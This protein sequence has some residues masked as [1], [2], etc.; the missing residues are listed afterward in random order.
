[1]FR[2]APL[3]VSRLRPECISFAYRLVEL[4]LRH[5]N[6][7]FGRA[8][9]LKI[10]HPFLRCA[11]TK[12]ETGRARRMALFRTRLFGS[13]LAGFPFLLQRLD[14]FEQPRFDLS[15]IVV[16]NFKRSIV[17]TRFHHLD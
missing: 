13:S 4:S 9:V 15:N 14:S 5:S 6:W 7:K 10:R 11:D 1:M 2:R 17:S 16:A 3:D 12:F 8:E